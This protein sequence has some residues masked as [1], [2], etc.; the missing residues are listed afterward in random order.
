MSEAYK[1]YIDYLIAGGVTETAYMVAKNGAILATNLP[2]TAFPAYNFEIEDEQDPTKTHNIVVEEGKNLIDAME[3]NG[4]TTHPA[5][6]R[7]YNQKYYTVRYD[8]NDHLLYLKKVGTCFHV[9]ARR[10]LRGHHQELL[11]HR[12]LQHPEQNGKRSP[13]EPRRAQQESR[14]FG[15]EPQKTGLLIITSNMQQ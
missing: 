9:G 11:H 1:P 13:P 3:H 4:V 2:I 6:I 12:Y 15:R 10:S 8:D 14:I 5:G 7:L